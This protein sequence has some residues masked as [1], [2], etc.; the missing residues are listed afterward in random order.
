MRFY[1]KLLI[2]TTL[3]I[4]ANALIRPA[5]A[6]QLWFDVRCDYAFR[7]GDETLTDALVEEASLLR[8]ASSDYL[9]EPKWIDVSCESDML[10][11]PALPDVL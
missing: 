4:S 11:L 5:A 1:L 9:D 10:P 2:L 6:R 3:A 7:I 8:S